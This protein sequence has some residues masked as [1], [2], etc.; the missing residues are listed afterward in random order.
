M[1]FSKSKQ[2]PGIRFDHAEIFA[3]QGRQLLFQGEIGHA[4]D[5]VHRRAQLV[6]DVGE[7]F[8]LGTIGPL[9]G[10]AGGAFFDKR[11]VFLGLPL[12]LQIHPIQ[13][14]EHR[15]LGPQ[16][17]GNDR[18]HDEIDGAQLVSADG[19]T[20]VGKR[21]QENDRRVFAALVAG[22][23]GRPFRSRRDPACSRRAG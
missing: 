4:D 3:D 15:H 19:E 2:Q 20:V 10:D 13:I 6:A 18:R 12:G 14:D 17:L 8:V 1:S 16:N 22:G 11:D 21:R 23:S 7:K 9:G 5:R